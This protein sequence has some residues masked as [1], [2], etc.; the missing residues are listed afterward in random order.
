MRLHDNGADDLRVYCEEVDMPVLF[1]DL[2]DVPL[3]AGKRAPAAASHVEVDARVECN[4]T[5][6]ADSYA[7]AARKV[8]D[9]D[10]GVP[11]PV[12]S[13][14]GVLTGHRELQAGG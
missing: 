9:Q 14:F 6:A 4:Q 3:E 8:K 13:H 2:G 5:Q 7:F 10:V 1:L 11:G 12:L